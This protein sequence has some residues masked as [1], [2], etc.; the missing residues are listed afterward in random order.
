MD[1]VDL[2]MMP[3]FRLS[4]KYSKQLEPDS[5][6]LGQAAD[7]TNEPFMSGQ[8]FSQFKLYN[9]RNKEFVRFKNYTY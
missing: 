6:H 1:S 8:G 4:W 2:D 7:K 5:I 3:G 9:P